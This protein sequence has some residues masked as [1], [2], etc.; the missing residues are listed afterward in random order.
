MNLAERL[1]NQ[2]VLLSGRNPGI[3]AT[4]EDIADYSGATVATWAFAAATLLEIASSNVND[5]SAGTGA[6]T[7]RIY[8]LDA[9][10]NYQTED[11]TLNGQTPVVSTK[12]FLRVWGAEV[13]TAG[14]GGVN[15]GNIH[16]TDDAEAWTAGVPNTTL[17]WACMIPIGDNVS[18]SGF[19]TVPA[20]QRYRLEWLSIGNRAQV[21]TY[22]L[23]T[24][25]NGGLWAARD[26]FELA[27]P[28]N[29]YQDFALRNSHLLKGP[30]ILSEKEDICIRGIAAVAG[31][32]GAVQAC[33]Q[34]IF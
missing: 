31:A 4:E 15:A 28:G 19:W 27:N 30:M 11:I 2:I 8:G 1:R 23:Y 7:I 3:A 22:K 17:Y 6:R 34:R 16:I 21:C 14:S 20:G 13:L 12:Q 29:V 18:H 25:L 33:L 24:R 9:N 32:V 5:T 10:Y 26:Y